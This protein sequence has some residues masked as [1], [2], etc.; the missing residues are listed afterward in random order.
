MI[1][2]LS[3]R[4]ITSFQFVT[5]KFSRMSRLKRSE[6]VGYHSRVNISDGYHLNIV[7]SFSDV[8]L[9]IVFHLH[10]FVKMKTHIKIVILLV[11]P[12]SA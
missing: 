7:L 12:V 6:I 10:K 9:A 11:V 5:N 4:E 8:K 1:R 2:K 3:L